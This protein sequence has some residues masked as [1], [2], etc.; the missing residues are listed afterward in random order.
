MMYDIVFVALEETRMKIKT[1]LVGIGFLIVFCSCSSKPPEV[2]GK[3]LIDIE[4]PHAEFV[5]SRDEN[6]VYQLSSSNVSL[7]MQMWDNGVKIHDELS[8]DTELPD[9]DAGEFN[10]IEVLWGEDESLLMHESVF[11]KMSVGLP[12]A[13]PFEQDETFK[14]RIQNGSKDDFEAGEIVTAVYTEPAFEIAKNRFVE[15]FKST[16]DAIPS[17]LQKQIETQVKADTGK[18]VTIEI[19]QRLET[20]ELRKV[21]FQISKDQIRTEGESFARIRFHWTAYQK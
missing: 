7:H 5:Y 2:V 14:M 17:F 21:P 9:K 20:I 12:G 19:R 16:F 1:F 11:N 4:I 18:S 15:Q 13:L 3:F 6:G 8:T 10:S